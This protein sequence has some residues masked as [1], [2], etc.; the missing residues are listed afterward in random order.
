MINNDNAITFTHADTYSSCLFYELKCM[1]RWRFGNLCEYLKAVGCQ[2]ST[3]SRPVAGQFFNFVPVD[4]NEYVHLT[5]FFT[6]LFVQRVQ[7]SGIWDLGSGIWDLGSG[8]WDQGS[9][10]TSDPR[11]QDLSTSTV[12]CRERHSKW[13]QSYQNIS[14]VV[15]GYVLSYRRCRCIFTP[16]LPTHV[17][18]SMLLVLKLM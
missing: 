4:T 11:S 9:I 12:G 7:G 3:R 16:N 18:R 17:N 1:L 8:I 10:S 14:C 5:S 13:I 2:F 6:V 15:V